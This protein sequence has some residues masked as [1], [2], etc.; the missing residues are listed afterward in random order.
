M[1]QDTFF[2]TLAAHFTQ[3]IP[4]ARECGMEVCELLTAHTVTRMPY[5]PEWLGDTERGVIH[6]GVVSS[7]VDSTSGLALLGRLGHFEPIAT[8]DLRMDYL[9]PAFKDR[10]IRCRAECYRVTTSIAFVRAQVW[11]LDPGEIVA[12]SKSVFMRSGSKRRR[13]EA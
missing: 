10:E 6:T 1:A 11:Q 12:T 9:R 8:L 13:T 5:R 4:H 7:L 2:E 3:S